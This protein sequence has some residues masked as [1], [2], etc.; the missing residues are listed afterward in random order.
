MS[1][2]LKTIPILFKAKH[3]LESAIRE[4]IKAQGLNPTEFGTLEILYS[5]GKQCVGTIQKK[6]LIEAS[7]LSYVLKTLSQ[8]GLITKTKDEKDTR[9]YMVDLTKEGK[10]QFAKIYENHQLA[11][12]KILDTLTDEE[13]KTLQHLLKKLGTFNTQ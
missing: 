13:E 3:A 1:D 2:N 6:V 12:R 8:K 7:S 11:M 9:R 5:K 4:N 10:A